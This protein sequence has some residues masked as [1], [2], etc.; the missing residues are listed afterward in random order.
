MVHRAAHYF[1]IRKLQSLSGVVPLGVFLGFHLYLN[2]HAASGPA[3]YQRAIQ[4]LQAFFP[5][6]LLILT[7]IG[8]IVLP[9]LFHAGAGLYLTTHMKSNVVQYPHPQNWLYWLQRMTGIMLLMFLLAHLATLRLGFGGPG[10]SVGANPDIAFEVVRFWLSQ[11]FVMAF[12]GLGIFSAAFH[13][14]NGLWSF[15]ISWG[16]TV[17]T[18]SQ[19]LFS[20]VCFGIGVLVF[21]LGIRI[22]LAFVN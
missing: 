6:P 15:A 14:A 3:A 18:Q 4:T 10:V 11:P 9:L 7:E 12:Y 5:G 20:Y 16:I 13:F 21:S 2:L 8:L 17:S 19:Q 22:L 1:F